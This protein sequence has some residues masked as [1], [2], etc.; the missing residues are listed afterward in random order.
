MPGSEGRHTFTFEEWRHELLQDPDLDGDAWR[1]LAL[2]APW[3]VDV[4]IRSSSLGG[5]WVSAIST[6]EIVPGPVRGM[7][8]ARGSSVGARP[9]AGSR[10]SC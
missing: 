1:S 3:L 9:W 4:D 5:G 10:A 7:A 8:T 2:Y 6:E